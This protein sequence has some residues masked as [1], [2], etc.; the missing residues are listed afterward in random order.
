MKLA[1]KSVR[2]LCLLTGF[3]ISVGGLAEWQY[4]MPGVWPDHQWLRFSALPSFHSGNA[5]ATF[6]PEPRH[7]FRS[8]GLN[9]RASRCAQPDGHCYLLCENEQAMESFTVSPGRVV[10]ENRQPVAVL[11][12]PGRVLLAQVRDGHLLVLDINSEN[13]SANSL[14]D[15]RIS[16]FTSHKDSNIQVTR[17]QELDTDK[18][19]A[20]PLPDQAAIHWVINDDRNISWVIVGNGNTLVFVRLDAFFA[21]MYRYEIYLRWKREM[22]RIGYLAGQAA[23]EPVRAP[24]NRGRK[25]RKGKARKPP[26]PAL[27][28]AIE[29]KTQAYGPEIVEVGNGK[30]ER[31][32]TSKLE[33]MLASE[34]QEK[35]ENQPR[36]PK[37]RKYHLTRARRLGVPEWLLTITRTGEVGDPVIQQW[38][39]LIDSAEEDQET[40]RLE[41][42]WIRVARAICDSPQWG[43]FIVAFSEQKGLDSHCQSWSE[44]LPKEVWDRLK[45][46]AISLSR[47]STEPP[48]P[49]AEVSGQLIDELLGL[50]V[51]EALWA[52]EVRANWRRIRAT[53]RKRR[54]KVMETDQEEGLPVSKQARPAN[55]DLDNEQELPLDEPSTTMVTF[56]AHGTEVEMPESEHN[57]ADHQ[58]V[59]AD[60]D[61]LLVTSRCDKCS[62]DYGTELF[63]SVEVVSKSVQTDSVEM[64]DKAVQTDPLEP[65][66]Q[67]QSGEERAI[68]VNDLIALTEQAESAPDKDREFSRLFLLYLHQRYKKQLEKK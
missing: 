52:M 8:T 34:E 63:E 10:N 19:H 18:S 28:P 41:L 47:S 12:Q 20:P 7:P 30:R 1:N 38:E 2:M 48:A 15:D 11:P 16:L 67:S 45:A 23:F 14:T 65:S 50:W 35:E 58:I 13:I 49:D 4:L 68:P 55:D 44:K 33:A 61:N 27:K 46:L 36:S 29:E 40:L 25:K 21:L 9:C 54:K 57:I 17:L 24:A 60:V 62:K 6:E 66:G 59:E 43:T 56:E 64:V 22:T 26:P 5:P 3:G 32:T 31:K 51:D 39:D 42:V 37:R 53:T